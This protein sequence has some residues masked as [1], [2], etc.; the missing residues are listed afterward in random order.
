MYTLKIKTLDNEWHDKDNVIL[1]AVFQLLA[2]FMEK[3]KPGKHCN[4][5][6]D[7]AHRKAWKELQKLYVW[8]MVQR[9]EREEPILAKGLKS[10]LFILEP[11]PGEPGFKHCVPPDKKKHVAWYAA[12]KMQEKAELR[13]FKED[14]TMLHRLIEVRP[15]MWT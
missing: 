13:W 2:D 14:Q 1:H 8:W 6:H 5:S 3:E 10:P 12:V 9:P 7:A 4:W 11:V 15:F